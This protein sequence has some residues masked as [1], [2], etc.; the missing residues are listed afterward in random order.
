MKYLARSSGSLEEGVWNSPHFSRCLSRFSFLAVT[1][2]LM[3]YTAFGPPASG[4]V[5]SGTILG[6]VT[7]QSGG[8]VANATVTATN[9]KTGLTRTV[10][11]EEQGDYL[12]PLLPLGQ[13]KIAVVAL[14]LGSGKAAIYLWL[15]VRGCE[16]TLIWLL[17]AEPKRSRFNQ[18]N[19]VLNTQSPEMGQ[20]IGNLAVTQLPLNGRQFIQ[21]ALLTPAVSNEVQGTLS[22]P[23]ALSGF[24][25]NAN[26]TRY[27]DNSYLLDGASIRD[28]VY[29]RLAVSPSIDAIEEFK[30][31]TSNYSAEFGGQGGAQVNISTRSGTNA[32]HGTAYEFL[33]N[34]VLD[35]R[36][37]FDIGKPPYRQNQFGGSI[38]GQSKKNKV[39]FFGNY[40]GQRIVKGVT[41]TA[42]VPTVGMRTGDFSGMAPVIDPLTGN[43]FP[44]NMI[45]A[46][47][48]APYATNLL[49]KIPLPTSA[50]LGRNFAGFGIRDA[51][52]DQFTTRLDYTISP[53]DL[54]FLRAICVL[55]RE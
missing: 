24:S 14:A 8:A 29:T 27:E 51:S 25:F 37:F 54:L 46:D 10:T 1:V 26:G 5:I 22:S 45:P 23:L 41:I 2:V 39:F 50:G 33:R 49:L 31:Q 34:D 21:L 16:L 44:N 42:A 35:A 3:L 18:Q 52:F 36:N 48:I 17:A 7:D 15:S 38:G 55:E 4:Q 28:P 43:P 30:V 19:P 40:E 12:I 53:K 47:R 11:T 9:L 32:F 6:T 13:Y 20:L